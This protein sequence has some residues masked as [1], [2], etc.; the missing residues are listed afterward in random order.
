MPPN[1]YSVKLSSIID[2]ISGG[3]PK[4]SETSYWN[5]D[6]GWLS[7]VDFNNDSRKVYKSEKTI[8]EKGLK[9]SNTKLLNVGDVI[10]SAR[11]TVGA[12]AQIGVP[13]CFNQSCF[14]LR[15]KS[16]IVDNDY[17]YYLLK[18]YIH[19][20]R[21][22]A[23]GSVF[24]TIN[25]D[26]FELM[27]L[28]IYTDINYQKKLIKIL[29]VIDDKIEL[30]NNINSTLE[31]LARTLYDYWFVQFDFPDGKGRPYKSSGGK[32]VYNE[33]LKREI[34][35]GWGTGTFKD[36]I[37]NYKGGDWGK[38]QVE[39]NYNEKVYCI[40]G[41]DYPS[42]IAGGLCNAPIRYILSNN[43]DKILKQNDLIIEISGGSP[44]HSTGRICYINNGLLN[45]FNAPLITSN[46]CRAVSC[47][48]NTIYNF[49]LEWGR[50]Y[51]SGMFFKYEGKTSGIKNLLLES[52]LSEYNIAL[53]EKTLITTFYNEV[54]P[55]FES[56]QQRLIENQKL[57]LIRDW[58]LP[59]LMNGQILIKN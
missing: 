37:V 21:K 1:S 12:L 58:L 13:L 3:T 5:G 23:Q 14:G 19:N 16:G 38:E 45:R 2:I 41:T 47:K 39:E 24:E 4:T 6:I 30:N 17:L 44:L 48:G 33:V 55:I 28:S 25:L 34:P 54:S 56:I 10:I 7:V 52:F 18:N 22:K 51:D 53:P 27:E 11:G 32:M 26:T 59:M 31:A 46:F 35:N 20:I 49:Y 43:T 40:R 29:S 36:Y 15:G 42:M 57:S 9:N 8:T 50:L